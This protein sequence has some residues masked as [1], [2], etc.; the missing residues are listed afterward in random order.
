[1]SFLL[2]LFNIMSAKTRKAF[3]KRFKVTGSGK[4]LR[5]SPNRRHLMRNKSTKQKRRSG[6]DQS[7]SKGF[8]AHVRRAMPNHF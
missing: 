6:Q 5:R 3:T 8:S 4:V 1:M 7:V 2:V